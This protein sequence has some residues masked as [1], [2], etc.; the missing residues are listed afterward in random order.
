MNVAVGWGNARCSGLRFQPF[1][2]AGLVKE[3]VITVTNTHQG[4]AGWGLA[5]KATSGSTLHIGVVSLMQIWVIYGDVA[6]VCLKWSPPL[7]HPQ[8]GI[9]FLWH[10]SA[11]VCDNLIFITLL[12]L[13][14]P[15]ISKIST[16]Y[17]S[18][19]LYFS[20]HDLSSFFCSWSS[21]N[22][23]LRLKWNQFF[24]GRFSRTFKIIW[25]FGQEWSKTLWNLRYED[26]NWMEHTYLASY[27]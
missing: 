22:S 2:Q 20:N 1:S 24:L 18:P 8:L 12:P 4:W 10:F 21:E 27:A 14:L 9:H 6:G 3:P 26:K 15:N 19:I 25:R 5:V 23:S 16:F 7:D 11:F 13:L 17:N